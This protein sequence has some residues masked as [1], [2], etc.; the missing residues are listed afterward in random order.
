MALGPQ[1]AFSRSTRPPRTVDRPRPP[2]TLS[3]AR[4]ER[5]AAFGRRRIPP[6]ALL[7]PQICCPAPRWCDAGL[8]AR[9]GRVESRTQSRKPSTGCRCCSNP[10]SLITSVMLSKAAE[11]GSQPCVFPG[12]TSQ[13][14]SWKFPVRLPS[15]QLASSGCAGL[16]AKPKQAQELAEETRCRFIRPKPPRFAAIAFCGSYGPGSRSVRE[17]DAVTD[18][19][20]AKTGRWCPAAPEV[21]SDITCCGSASGCEGLRESLRGR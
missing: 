20:S 13:V 2:I 11:C 16:A 10:M 7:L 4:G 15:Q 9:A 21:R 1:R 12:I 19:R 6:A 5:P 18:P 17:L 3:P 8:S 14:L